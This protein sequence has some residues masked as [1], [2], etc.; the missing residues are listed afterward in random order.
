VKK[1]DYAG[2]RRDF[3]GGEGGMDLRGPEPEKLSRTE[4][5]KGNLWD[6]IFR[7]YR[8]GKEEQGE[9][10][11]A[12]SKEGWNANLAPGRALGIS[13]KSSGII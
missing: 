5:K 2:N 3:S 1:S 7:H 10:F 11:A 12:Y 13:E 6:S 9:G 4:G 8:K